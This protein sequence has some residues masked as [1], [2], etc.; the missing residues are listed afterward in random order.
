M[1]TFLVVG[2]AARSGVVG[3]PARG[4][5]RNRAPQTDRQRLVDSI[6]SGEDY[7][8]HENQLGINYSTVRNIIRVWL[9]DGRVETMARRRTQC[10]FHWCHG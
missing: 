10:C 2:G 5:A 3:R 8:H 9:Q 1:S 6:E 4:G 7:L